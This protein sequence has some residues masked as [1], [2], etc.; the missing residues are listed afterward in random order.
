MNRATFLQS[1]SVPALLVNA[2]PNWMVP[3]KNALQ[4]SAV[5]LSSIS[6]LNTEPQQYHA[7]YMYSGFIAGIQYYAASEIMA[8]LKEGLIA[9]LVREPDN[10][11]D[12]KAVAIYA[13][14]RKLGYLQRR[15]N[16]VLCNILDAGLPI[17]AEISRVNP[18][19]VSYEQIRI[20]LYLV[21]VLPNA[22]TQTE[23][24]RPGLPRT[25]ALQ[26]GIMGTYE[27]I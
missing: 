19:A 14:G 2:V 8:Q 9:D 21:G 17:Y 7:T 20:R 1:L 18:E 26:K 27:R 3:A 13:L 11:Y 25:I 4:A 22:I 24:I 5:G 23:D 10:T 16:L 12:Y 6:L 15:H